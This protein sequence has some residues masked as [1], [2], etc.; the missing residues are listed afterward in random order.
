MLTYPGLGFSVNVSFRTRVNGVRSYF[1]GPLPMG[2]VTSRR[3]SSSSSLG[4]FAS[5][6]CRRGGSHGSDQGSAMPA[7]GAGFPTDLLGLLTHCLCF[8]DAYQRHGANQTALFLQD[9]SWRPDCTHIR[10]LM[11]LH[12]RGQ[13][14]C[15]LSP[16][17]QL[18]A[19]FHE[20]CSKC[21]LPHGCPDQA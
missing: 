20:Y 4:L 9:C 10:T 2:S 1:D 11:T 12:T 17:L 3:H 8:Y 6:W 18:E 7:W 19:R 13:P 14:D 16:R 15:A 5:Y 21:F